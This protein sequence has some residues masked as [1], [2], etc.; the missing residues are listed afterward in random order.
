MKSPAELCALSLAGLDFRGPSLFLIYDTS[1][2]S[3][4]SSAE[5]G[6]HFESYCCFMIHRAHTVL[7]HRHLSYCFLKWNRTMIWGVVFEYLNNISSTFCRH[8]WICPHNISCGKNEKLRQSDGIGFAHKHVKS[9]WLRWKWS[10]VPLGLLLWQPSNA[11][12]SQQGT[13]IYGHH[14]FLWS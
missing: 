4:L 2:S 11:Q 8:R 5:L 3:N 10:Q 13:W 6:S 1:K 7:F 9:L 12:C 14:D